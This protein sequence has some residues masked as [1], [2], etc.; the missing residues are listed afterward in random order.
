MMRKGQSQRVAKGDIL[1]QVSAQRQEQGKG[2][3]MDKSALLEIRNYCTIALCVSKFFF[4]L[5]E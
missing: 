3:L 5:H 2:N 1:G 4:L